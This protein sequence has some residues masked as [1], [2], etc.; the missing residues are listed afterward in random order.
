MQNAGLFRDWLR[1]AGHAV[2]IK[3]GVLLANCL[4]IH[5]MNPNQQRAIL[6]QA[7]NI[8]RLNSSCNQ[9]IAPPYNKILSHHVRG[10]N[11]LCNRRI[12]NA[13]TAS[14]EAAEEFYTQIQSQKDTNW[15]LPAIDVVMLQLR[16]TSYKAD[17]ELSRTGKKEKYAIEAQDLLKRFF[18]RFIIDRTQLEKSKKLGC[19]FVIG[20]LFKIYFKINNLRLCTN[21]M[22]SVNNPNF[23]KFERFPKAQVVTYNYYVGRIKVFEEQYEEAEIFLNSA[24]NMCARGHFRNKRKILQFLIPVKLLLGKFPKNRLLAK[25]KLHQFERLI[26]AV[27]TGNLKLFKQSMDEFQE[28]FIKKGIFL[29]LEKLTKDVYRNL[30]KKVHKF[31]QIYGEANK[32]NQIRLNML[33]ASLKINGIEMA[34]DELEC[35]LSNLIYEGAIKGYIAHKRCVVVS[36]QNPFP[37]MKY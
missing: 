35:I 8:A 19:L 20:H 2:Q 13:Y 7:I 29:M 24:F 10:Y 36:K 1:N 34:M 22:T 9:S 30:F 15:W 33:L 18:Q 28:F 16:L 26:L 4:A 5:K 31:C 37:K 14:K 23:P 21:L 6:S 32:K 12:F 27:T 11:M 17:G 3:N 25:Y